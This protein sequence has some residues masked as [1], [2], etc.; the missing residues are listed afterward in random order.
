MTEVAEM[1]RV[2]VPAVVENLFDQMDLAKGR[3]TA[4]QI[5]RIE[6]SEALVD[7]GATY[8][9]LP[10]SEIAKLGL[11]PLTE[12]TIRRANGPRTAKIYGPVKLLVQDRYCNTDVLELP[13][14]VPVLIGQVPLELMDF[15]VD[16]PNRRLIGNPEHGGEWAVE[17]Y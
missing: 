14:D 9:C 16:P 5:R 17:V 4:D 7:T 1:G 13:E 8:L 2:V 3:I 15:V 12:R 10:A 6:I 11:T